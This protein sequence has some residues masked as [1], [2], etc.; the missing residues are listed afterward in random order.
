MLYRGFPAIEIQKY[1]E[2]VKKKGDLSS[3]TLKKILLAKNSDGFPALYVAMQKGHSESIEAYFEGLKEL[4]KIAGFQETI[5]NILQ[6]ILEA[7]ATSKT[8]AKPK[9]KPRPTA[10]RS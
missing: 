2:D 5:K 6:P 3:E 10:C 8:T 1:F 4:A 9:P 7:K